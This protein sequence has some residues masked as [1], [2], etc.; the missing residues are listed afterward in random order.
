MSKPKKTPAPIKRREE[1]LRVLRAARTYAQHGR[2]FNGRRS[3][4][5]MLLDCL[6]QGCKDYGYHWPAVV[7]IVDPVPAMCLAYVCQTIYRCNDPGSNRLRFKMIH[8]FGGGHSGFTVQRLENAVRIAMADL[9][10]HRAAHKEGRKPVP[11]DPRSVPNNTTFHV[12]Y[13]RYMQAIDAL[14][15]CEKQLGTLIIEG[16][17]TTKLSEEECAEAR[18]AAQSAIHAS[19]TLIGEREDDDA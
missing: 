7:T 8:K 9:K 17:T 5:D 3:V 12:P 13:D 10:E 2:I 14:Q 1:A 11:I 6:E 18:A 15:K 19:V 4:H 16:F